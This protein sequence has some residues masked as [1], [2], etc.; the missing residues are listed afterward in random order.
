VSI[1]IDPPDGPTILAAR[2]L[3]A[4][5]GPVQVGRTISTADRSAIDRVIAYVA[6]AHNTPVEE[7]PVSAPLNLTAEQLRSIGYALDALT[8][9]TVELGVSL[10]P[11]GRLALGLGENTLSVSWD[12]E[13]YVIDDRNGD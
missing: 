11:H 1:T 5:E 9:V 13:A 8:K 4:T 3:D 12:G 2:H 6:K 10:T 7:T